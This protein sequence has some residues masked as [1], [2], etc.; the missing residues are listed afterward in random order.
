M[1]HARIHLGLVIDASA[2][3]GPWIATG[4]DPAPL[5]LVARVNGEVPQSANTRDMIFGI[6]VLRNTVVPRSAP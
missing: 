5:D 3:L 6:R 4:L 2:P 1:A